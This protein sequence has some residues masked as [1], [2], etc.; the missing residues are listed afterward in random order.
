MSNPVG[1]ILTGLKTA[2]STVL[3][4]SYKELKYVYS[5]EDNDV[6][7]MKKAYGV[8]VRDGGSVSGITKNATI[9]QQFFVVLTDRFTNRSKDANERAV[10][11]SL[12][13]QI[14]NLNIEIFQKKVNAP[15]VVLAVQDISLGEP[16]RIDK[17]AIAITIEYTIKYRSQT[18]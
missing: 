10:I 12:Y 6:T 18:S 16:E 13:E 7:A 15:S 1:T 11:S 4:A 8:G 17:G 14:D 9:D 5:L 3:G 2:V